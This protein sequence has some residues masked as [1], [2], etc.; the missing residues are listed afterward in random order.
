MKVAT[1]VSVGWIVDLLRR[2][3]L[4]N[5]ALVEHGD[6]VAQSHRLDLVVSDVDRRGAEPALEM[7]ELIPSGVAQLGVQIR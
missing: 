2:P 4:A 7:L 1:K 5:L 6:P 3:D